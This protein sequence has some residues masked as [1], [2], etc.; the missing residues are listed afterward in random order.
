MHA[1]VCGT[2]RHADEWRNL[3][4][5]DET[6]DAAATECAADCSVYLNDSR[7]CSNVTRSAQ[8]QLLDAI[9]QQW[10]DNNRI[11]R[12]HAQKSHT[13]QLLENALDGGGSFLVLVT[14]GKTHGIQLGGGQEF[15]MAVES[16]WRKYERGH[17]SH[18]DT[19]WDSN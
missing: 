15:G 19:R 16:R 12:S 5:A 3:C 4:N 8:W 1:K 10:A 13:Y 7:R 14:D 18:H 6:R 2:E 9:C 17:R 11:R